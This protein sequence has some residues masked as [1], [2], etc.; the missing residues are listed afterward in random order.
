MVLVSVVACGNGA[1]TGG[2]ARDALIAAWQKG[3][4][5]PSAFAAATSS[6]VG[7]DCS[8][9]TVNSVDVLVC[10]FPTADAAKAAHDAGL[11]WV[12]DT[13]GFANEKGTLLIAAADRRKADPTGATL[14]KLI[15]LAP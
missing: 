1:S 6:P 14:N 10:V 7:K 4:L 2:G 3:G 11:Q 15:K 13:S 9:G 5:A 12:G 8:A